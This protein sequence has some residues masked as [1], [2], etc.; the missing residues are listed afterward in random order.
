MS[1]YS[2]RDKLL[3]VQMSTSISGLQT[4]AAHIVSWRLDW[5]SSIHNRRLHDEIQVCC[6]WMLHKHIYSNINVLYVCIQLP[7]VTRGMLI[8]WIAPGLF[9]FF[10]DVWTEIWWWKTLKTSSFFLISFFWKC[11]LLLW[12]ILMFLFCFVCDH[13]SFIWC[14]SPPGLHVLFTDCRHQWIHCI[15]CHLGSNINFQ[16]SN[17]RCSMEKCWGSDVNSRHTHSIVLLIY[18]WVWALRFVPLA[19]QNLRV[20]TVINVPSTAEQR[21]VLLERTKS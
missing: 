20:N 4:L 5:Y 9:M 19:S 21:I 6:S 17:L 13:L 14:F 3:L 18:C 11:F 12:V 15:V 16:N 7:A 2:D 10:V 1:V 8:G